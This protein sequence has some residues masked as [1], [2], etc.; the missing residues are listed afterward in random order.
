M[1]GKSR[2]SH[3]KSEVFQRDYALMFGLKI[4]CNQ[5]IDKSQLAWE[6]AL[7]LT[8]IIFKIM[9]KSFKIN[10]SSLYLTHAHVCII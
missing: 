7:T 2:L 9:F 3:D 8:M 5:R 4:W 10:N 1:Q 6:I